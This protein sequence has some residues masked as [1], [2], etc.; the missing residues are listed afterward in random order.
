MRIS[1]IVVVLDDEIF[2]DKIHVLIFQFIKEMPEHMVSAMGLDHNGQ[3]IIFAIRGRC[4]SFLLAFFR[5][6]LV[7]LDTVFIGNAGDGAENS[8]DF[9]DG[10]HLALRASN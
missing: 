6:Q 1:I 5:D 2:H 10:A 4:Q 7:D 8:R 9:L 3:S